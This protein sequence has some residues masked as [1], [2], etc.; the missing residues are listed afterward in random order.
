[1]RLTFTWSDA[2]V[3]AALTV[4]GGPR[5]ADLKDILEAGDL[6]NCAVFSPLEL[7]RG[8]AKLARAHYV[9]VHGDHF[10]ISGLARQAIEASLTKS[11][12]PFAVLQ[13]FEDFLE[14][15]MYRPVDD[16]PCD[17]SLPGLDHERVDSACHS[18]ESERV[19]AKN[20]A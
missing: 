6:I 9:A 19:A 5:G 18:Y 20:A 3:L 4:G 15:D 12:L 1:M 2:W 17:W 14:V 10:M 7:R 16:E 13:F 8:I 11:V